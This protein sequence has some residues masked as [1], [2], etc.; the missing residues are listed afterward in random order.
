MI[1]KKLEEGWQWVLIMMNTT[2]WATQIAQGRNLA[3]I[4]GYKMV[5]FFITQN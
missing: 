1:G 3:Y 5:S 4:P 2:V